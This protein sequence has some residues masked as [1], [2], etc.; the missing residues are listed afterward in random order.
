MRTARQPLLRLTRELD[1]YALFVATA[2]FTLVATAEATGG[3]EIPGGTLTL[4]LY[5]AALL[6][7]DGL[8]T[9]DL[10]S[11]ELRA[12]AAWSLLV[13][14]A[15]V[16]VPR[17]TAS[18]LVAVGMPIAIGA[19]FLT[20]KRPAAAVVI[21]MLLTGIG[22]TFQAY[23]GLSPSPLI[24]L[25]L[26]AIWIVVL[27]RIVLGR[28]YE[29]VAWPAILGCCLYFGLTIVD[30]ATSDQ[31]GV[32]W[33]GFHTTVWFMLAFVA[34][35]YA[36]WSRETYRRIAIGFVGVT[37]LLA[38]YA[39][40][41]W[42]IGPSGA[43][44]ELATIAG[45]GINVDPIDK[46]LKTVGT[47]NTAHQLAFWA[48]FMGPFCAAV[49]LWATGWRR[50]MALL[51]VVLCV[52]AMAASEARAPLVGFVVGLAVVLLLHQAAR[53]F[54]GFKGGILALAVAGVAVVGGGALA[55]SAS[56][57]AELARYTRILEPNSDPTFI[58]RQ[59]KWDQVMQEVD[60]HPFGKGL[61]TGG[62]GASRSPYVE[63]STFNIDNSYLKI[64]YEQGLLVMAL[65]VAAILALLARMAVGSMRT[66]SR[67]GAALAFGACG[68]LASMLVSFYTGLYIEVPAVLAG[69]LVVGLGLSHL[70]TREAAETAP[71]SV[72]EREARLLPGG[73]PAR[74]AGWATLRAR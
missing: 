33:F 22:G 57:P 28:P 11:R 38:G 37:A 44:A 49:A 48:A 65:F 64:A 43:E 14:V 9:G 55:L 72:R 69:W 10:L 62:A 1:R 46:H 4:C 36:G 31:I 47:F 71:A 8:R 53:A 41:R 15:F 2:A 23:L 61:G 45:G 56:D 50:L 70:V 6:A 20:A 19:G 63:L 40:L 3:I 39:T 18:G 34:M 52:S 21:A 73:A 54:P 35:A 5:P 12:C 24:D 25:A 58:Q 17:L 68:T 16:L 29:F 51:G 42:A 67:E 32:A 60:D 7:M 74:A 27:A 26:A 59:L 13:P 30:L 66:L